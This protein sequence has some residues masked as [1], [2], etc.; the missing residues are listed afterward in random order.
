MKLQGADTKSVYGIATTTHKTQT[1]KDSKA[2]KVFTVKY[3]IL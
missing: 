2:T 3:I 1:K